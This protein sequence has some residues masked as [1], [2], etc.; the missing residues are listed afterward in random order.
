MLLILGVYVIHVAIVKGHHWVVGTAS[1]GFP[2]VCVIH[3]NSGDM[4]NVVF[5]CPLIG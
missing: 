4:N 5:C 1:A 3:G 2:V